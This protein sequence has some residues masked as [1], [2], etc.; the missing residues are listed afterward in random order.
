MLV[1]LSLLL[2]KADFEVPILI[3]GTRCHPKRLMVKMSRTSELA[4]KTARCKVLARFPQIGWE[5]V[6]IQNPNLKE[7][8]SQI[9]SILGDGSA[10]YDRAAELAY[11]PNDP[12]WPD[13]WHMRTIKA[14][15]A[16]DVSKGS[17][18]TIVGLIDTGLRTDHEDLAA[19][20]WVNSGEIP[21]NNLDD[22]N[23]GYIDDVNGFDFAYNTGTPTDTLGH[24][25]GC[26]GIIGAVQDNNLGVSGACPKLKIMALK[27][28]NDS[29]YLFDSY[30]VPAYIYGADHGAKVF[31]MSFFSDRVSQSEKD[32]MDYAVAHG[33]L[34]VAAAGNDASVLPFY[35]GA[36]ENVLSVAATSESNLKSGFSNYGTWVDVAA[37]G[38]NLRTTSAGGGYQG[39]AGTSGACPHVSGVAAL[40]FGA[41]PTA[42]ATEVR[43]AIEDTAQV[44]N[45]APYGE[46]ANYGLINASAALTALLGTPA[47]PKSVA[48]RYIANLGQGPVG[49]PLVPTTFFRARMYGRGFEGISNLIIKR[50]T[51]TCL[52]YERTRNWIDF[53]NQDRWIGDVELF[54]GATRLAV[55]KVPITHYVCN[56]LVEASGI[57]SSVT[58]G[59]TETLI[60]DNITMNVS[61][62]GAGK[63]TMQGS[64]R[65]ISRLL[66]KS[67]QL[68][69]SYSLA[70]GIEN[71]M[72]YDWASASYPYGNWVTIATNPAPTTPTNLTI[73]LPDISRY[74]DPE[75]TTYIRIQVT[76]VAS[77][78]ILKLD[79]L[80]LHDLF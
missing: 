16:W 59:F 42:T 50:G 36:Y 40:L 53:E 13:Q 46:F 66:K 70:G 29:G 54:D 73:S 4:V 14:D 55:V 3:D 48:V 77:G 60:N 67:L 80:G 76:G 61:D 43:N 68:R 64:L 37:P 25:T 39:F 79:S 24:G 41:K 49:F 5:S 8:K 28:C 15:L 18:S 20:V 34:P 21:G 2:S 58:G 32:A 47:P 56:P 52:I 9:E 51:R 69:R 12:L 75:K 72:I 78:T 45:Q 65:R 57:G 74:V 44:L 11:T 6:E 63:I 31:S 17:N 38:Q 27:A 10:Q 33:V 1:P 23:D 30:L 22:E 7:S 71:I 26:A 35:P 19:N 62:D